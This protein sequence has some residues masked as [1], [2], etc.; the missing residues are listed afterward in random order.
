MFYD[1]LSPQYSYNYEENLMED[2]VPHEYNLSD[3]IENYQ[4]HQ[5][6]KFNNPMLNVLYRFYQLQNNDSEEIKI[7]ELSDGFAK[8]WISDKCKK[9]DKIELL[10]DPK[11]WP[12]TKAE[13]KNIKDFKKNKAAKKRDDA[14]NPLMENLD[15]NIEIEVIDQ[16]EH[17][18]IVLR[19]IQA[20]IRSDLEQLITMHYY[21]TWLGRDINTLLQS[22]KNLWRHPKK[23]NHSELAEHRHLVFALAQTRLTHLSP[24]KDNVK[25]LG[26]LSDYITGKPNYPESYKTAGK[27]LMGIGIGLLIATFIATMCLAVAASS[28][29]ATIAAGELL[30]NIMG[31]V[32]L[33]GMLTAGLTALLGAWIADKGEKRGLSA[34]VDNV[35]KRIDI[36]ITS[37]RGANNKNVLSDSIFKL[38]SVPH[39]PKDDKLPDPGFTGRYGRSVRIGWR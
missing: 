25:K 28:P 21:G 3:K 1:T 14:T 32:L 30:A 13:M 34:T 4:N 37:G 29:T 9:E 18:D 5:D 15:E 22:T 17:Q 12:F 31:I 8:W 16:H 7:N 2:R 36:R 6:D 11:L 10:S 20:Q 39:A 27:V 35:A 26:Q 38:H 24:T 33:S 19:I 23:A